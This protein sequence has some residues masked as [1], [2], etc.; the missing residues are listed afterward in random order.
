[1]FFLLHQLAALLTSPFGHGISWIVDG[2][3]FSIGVDVL[4]VVEQLVGDETMREEFLLHGVY[5]WTFFDFFG[6]RLVFG[7]RD[8]SS[9]FSEKIECLP[10]M[11][12]TVECFLVRDQ[13]YLRF[14]RIGMGLVILLAAASRTGHQLVHEN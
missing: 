2:E 7:G 10:R 1:M 9:K 13:T 14:P 12:M 6:S 3:Q 11:R 5:R 4:N 8:F